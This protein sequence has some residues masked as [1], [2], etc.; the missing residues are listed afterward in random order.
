MLSK[1]ISILIDQSIREVYGVPESGCQR[2]DGAFVARLNVHRT[3]CFEG[4]TLTFSPHNCVEGT[5]VKRRRNA[6]QTPD[7]GAKRL[8]ARQKAHPAAQRDGC[9]MVRCAQQAGRSVPFGHRVEFTPGAR[10]F[11]SFLPAPH[12]SH[13]VR[14]RVSPSR[15]C[16]VHVFSRPRFLLPSLFLASAPRHLGKVAVVV[17]PGLYPSK[18]GLRSVREFHSQ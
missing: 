3:G 14:R 10:P 8:H 17:C 13:A 11:G 1:K 7:I 12:A 16:C 6:R 2:A 5:M 18:A 9:D 15:S 4:S